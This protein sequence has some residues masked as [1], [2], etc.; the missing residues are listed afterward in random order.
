MTVMQWI[1]L[2]ELGLKVWEALNKEGATDETKK[3]SI[4]EA[5]GA[6]IPMLKDK[7]AEQVTEVVGKDGEN[8][9]SILNIIS[10]IGGLF[11]KKS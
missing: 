5:L 11:E 4:V 7:E 6:I 1:M 9:T 10:K 2:I 8:I 3:A